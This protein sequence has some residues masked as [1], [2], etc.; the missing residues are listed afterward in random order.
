MIAVEQSSKKRVISFNSGR[1]MD[2]V[3]EVMACDCL[4]VL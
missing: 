4:R 1:F 2:R 3:D